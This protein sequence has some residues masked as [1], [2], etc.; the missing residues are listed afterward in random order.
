MILVTGATG[1]IGSEILRQLAGRGDKVRA[2]TRDPERATVPSGIEVVRG[3]YTDPASMA[4][5]MTGTRAVFLVSVLGPDDIDTDRALITTAV[6]AGVQRVVKL[7]AI[8]TGDPA[9]G[10]VGTWHLPGEQAVRDSGLE[11]TILRPSSFASNTLR[12]LDALRAG[13]PA[14]N[15]TGTATQGIIDP[16]DIAAVA[17]EALT[18]E[19]HAGHTYTLTG[20]EL[21]SVPDQA[22][23]LGAALGREVPVA[24]LPEDTAR[25]H[26]LEAGMTAEYVDGALA[27]QRYVLE[28]RNAVVTDDVHRV[29]GRAPR[30]FAEWAA[31]HASAFAPDGDRSAVG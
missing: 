3:D 2:V 11:W 9:L 26:M 20:A 4:A 29:L 27:G 8:G 21:L 14:P 16:R 30:T 5:A 12:W 19:G 25:Q 31:D 23:I 24:D 18:A 10:R 7:S 13:H 28:G 22:A 1:T 6:S 17:V 15:L